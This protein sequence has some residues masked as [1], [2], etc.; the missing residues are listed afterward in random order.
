MR[1]ENI[2]KKYTG[3]GILRYYFPKVLI[4]VLSVAIIPNI[5]DYLGELLYL[6]Y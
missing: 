2:S 5:L 1:L 3:F 4:I 6:E